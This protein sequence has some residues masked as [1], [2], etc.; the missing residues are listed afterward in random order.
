MAMDPATLQIFAVIAVVMGVGQLF[1]GVSLLRSAEA[2]KQM[3]GCVMQGGGLGWLAAA[4]IAYLARAQDWAF[5]VA[6]G[7]MLAGS[8][9]GTLTGVRRMKARGNDQQ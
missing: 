5:M 3:V 8:G 9:I 7:A 4:A 2:S 6:L 1:Y